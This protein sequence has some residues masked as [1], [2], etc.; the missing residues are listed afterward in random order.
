MGYRNFPTYVQ[1]MIDRIFRP[2]RKYS[3]IY[4]DD[5][6]IFSFSLQKHVKYFDEMFNALLIKNIHLRVTNIF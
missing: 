6:I 1:R 3:K 4:V 5:I 2:H